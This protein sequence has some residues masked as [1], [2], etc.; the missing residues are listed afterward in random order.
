MFGKRLRVSRT[1][2]GLSLRDL[3]KKI[4]NLVTAQAISRYERDE[5]FPSP[6]VLNELVKALSVTEDY[7]LNDDQLALTNVEFRKK[8]ITSRKE[9]IQVEGQTIHRL[10]NYLFVE[11]LLGL[12]TTD[13]DRPRGSPYRVADVVETEQIASFVRM[14]WN[15][16]TNPIP[17]MVE[18]M[19]ERGVK[20][21]SI[22]LKSIDGLTARVS[23]QKH[24]GLPVIVVNATQSGERQRFTLSHE[25]G[26]MVM[27]VGSNIDDE[28]AAHR[29][30]G[31]FLMPSETL[32]SEI[33]NFRK[34]IG[35]EEMLYLK[36]LFGV[37][38]QA[39]TYRCRYLGIINKS[40]FQS[41]LKI[42]AEL[43]W[44]RPPFQEPNE[45]TPEKPMRFERLCYRAL[46]EKLLSNYEAAELLGMTVST[47][48]IKLNSP[49]SSD[50]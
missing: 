48:E 32:R 13:W 1:A 35:W 2:S 47:V 21:F 17:N 6:I 27:S 43:G 12:E 28:D 42:F 8:R 4:D 9:E 23:G 20:V 49:P 7:L 25:L 24:R 36:K 18:L 30:A 37:S 16:G 41:H 39:L 31:A 5:V 14:S 15:L 11:N 44:S 38:F 22:G 40:L 3:S 10:E 46:S 34:S 19:E 26:H 29:F 50:N 45:S 33:G